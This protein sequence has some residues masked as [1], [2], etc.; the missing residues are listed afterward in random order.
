MKDL[1][2]SSGISHNQNYRS[3]VRRKVCSTGAGWEGVRQQQG[4]V[5]VSLFF[6]SS[7]SFF[8][9]FLS[10]SSFSVLFQI[11]P[12]MRDRPGRPAVWITDCIYSVDQSW[13]LL[14]ENF[15]QLWH[16]SLHTLPFQPPINISNCRFSLL[17]SSRWVTHSIFNHACNSVANGRPN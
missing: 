14:N 9:F 8:L 17:W 10:S 2:W 1:L 16:A 6:S 4:T 7:V 11:V 5:H 3:G 12:H 13:P 15:S